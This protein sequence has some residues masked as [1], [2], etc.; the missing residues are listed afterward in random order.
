MSQIEKDFYNIACDNIIS[1]LYQRKP[2]VVVI[3]KSLP[4]NSLDFIASGAI[5]DVLTAAFGHMTRVLLAPSWRASGTVINCA[6]II[7]PSSS[8]RSNSSDSN[9]NCCYLQLKLVRA[10]FGPF[11]N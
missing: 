11:A 1:A 10:C 3:E 8:N 6:S 4:L 9:S 7:F 2:L 5:G